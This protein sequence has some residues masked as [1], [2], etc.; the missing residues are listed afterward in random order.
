MVNTTFNSTQ[1]SSRMSSDTLQDAT[2]SVRDA[3]VKAREFADTISDKATEYYH[4]AGDWL[5]ENYG[6]V[7]GGT[8]IVAGV[9]MIGY[10]L[11]RSWSSG[12]LLKKT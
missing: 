1:R 11:F 3:S 8:A 4:E 9:G 10:Y 7:L 6:K 2:H 5:G 12:T